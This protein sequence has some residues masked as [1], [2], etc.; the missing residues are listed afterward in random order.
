MI[1]SDFKSELIKVGVILRPHGIKG[2]VKVKFFMDNED[3]NIK[4]LCS[5]SP[6]F[7][8]EVQKNEI[9][10][11]SVQN[12]N[13]SIRIVSFVD[14]DSRNKALEIQSKYLY[15]KRSSF[16]KINDKSVY[17]IDLVDCEVFTFENTGNKTVT[18]KVAIGIV[19]N[20]VDYGSIPLLN[21]KGNKNNDEFLIPFH[22]DTIITKDNTLLIDFNIAK[23]YLELS[24][25]KSK[26]SKE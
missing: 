10:L 5:Y 19:K 17:L 9:K 6:I 15:V 14:Y 20:I 21:I 26:K 8:S 23:K 25:N 12:I 2:A 13:S 3:V 22:N 7:L 11:E 18:S 1:D 16:P 4:T 24:L